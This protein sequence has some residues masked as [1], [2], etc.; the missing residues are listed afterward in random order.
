MATRV[1]LNGQI[2]GA[3]QAVVPVFD[4][5]F[6]YGD[7]VYEVMRTYGG[8]P[9]A[10]AAHWER[11]ES[12]AR[13]LGMSLGWTT[14]DAT[15]ALKA[16]LE[17]SGNAESYVRVVV[18][19][20]AGPIGLDP[21]LATT[22]NRVIIVKELSSPPAELYERGC[23]L[24]IVSVQRSGAGVDPRAKSGNYLSSIQA[25]REALAAGAY[26][27]VMKNAEG[28]LCEGSSSNLFIVRRGEVATPPLDAGI[29]EGITR[30]T[31]MTIC[32]RRGILARER[33]LQADDLYE[34]DEAFITSSIREVM[35]VAS[36]DDH[37]IASG[38]P[39]P[40]TRAITDV[41]RR[42]ATETASF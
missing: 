39:G 12:S 40:L 2:V 1:F 5:G 41:Y 4:R 10:W 23:K 9:F 33:T 38:R 30:R 35:P 32:K 34:A 13:R 25:L 37:T 31:V 15:T 18:T 20:G 6:L 27:A 19:R 22:P 36:C 14:A 11:L 29:L 8:K 17:E 24:R 26:E 7:S 21:A 3:E 28:A 42:I 16:T